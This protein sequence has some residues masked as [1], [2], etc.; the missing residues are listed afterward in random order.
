MWGDDSLEK[1]IKNPY[2]LTELVGFG[3]VKADVIA[4]KI[5]ESVPKGLRMVACMKY[6]L[7]EN[8]YK[9]SNLC[10]PLSDLKG[11]VLAELEKGTELNDSTSKFVSGEYECLFTECIKNNLNIFVAVKDVYAE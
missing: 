2:M 7:E 9:N 3:F 5:L 10:M 6:C 11:K 4:H 1:L 8:L